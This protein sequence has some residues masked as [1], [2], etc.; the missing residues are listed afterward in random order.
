MPE[1]EPGTKSTHPMPC[2]PNANLDG[3][4]FGSG[5][6]VQANL[7]F[8]NSGAHVRKASHFSVYNNVAP[9]LNVADYP[10][11]FPGQYT[12]APTPGI[13]V[14]TVAGSVEIGAGS[15]DGAYDITIVGPNRFLR[16]FTG[17]VGAPGLTAQAQAAY[18]PHG[19]A[20]EP[21]LWLTLT[22]K[23]TE[24]VA[25]TVTPNHYSDERPRIYR[26]RAHDTAMHV[27]DPLADG[28]GWY[29]IT[30]TISSDNSWSRR[31]VGHLEDGNNSVTG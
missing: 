1:Q 16:H 28:H 3:F 9:D 31:F 12:V 24:T 23:S 4:T 14:K 6:A 20:G 15:G 2:Q 5:G 30:V 19:F 17:D 22:N 11:K 10:A 27:A 18:S 21:R 25:F 26:V 29:D 8:S 13:W 7:S